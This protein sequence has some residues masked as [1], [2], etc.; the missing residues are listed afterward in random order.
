MTTLLIDAQLTPGLARWITERF[1]YECYS[2][3]HM[4]MHRAEGPEIFFK[5]RE[6][7]AMVITKDSDFLQLL[8][9]HGPP[10]KIIWLT[11]GNTS[12]QRMR[13]IFGKYLA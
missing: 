7:N 10:P 4:G 5:A 13:E 12:N 9:R 6:M 2:L 11:C 8:D 3:R 1:G